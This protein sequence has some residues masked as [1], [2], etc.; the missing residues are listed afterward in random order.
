[1]KRFFSFLFLSLLS[2]GARAEGYKSPVYLDFR[3][4]REVLEKCAP[5]ATPEIMKVHCLG[6]IQGISDALAL[7]TEVAD[8]IYG[9]R[10]CRPES[11]TAG[12]LRDIVIS[13]LKSHPEELRFKSPSV[14]VKILGE[15]FPCK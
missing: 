10:A 9:Y 15:T 5:T 8:G 1:M 11:I 4:G 2:V 7:A 12:Q 6:Y 14:V 13:Y 3:T